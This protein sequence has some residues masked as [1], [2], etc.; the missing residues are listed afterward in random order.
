MG[1]M[2]C[3]AVEIVGWDRYRRALGPHI[4]GNDG[5]EVPVWET[6]I[7]QVPFLGPFYSYH[8]FIPEIWYCPLLYVTNYPVADKHRWEET[9]G[10][11]LVVICYVRKL[12]AMTL[13][14]IIPS[15]SSRTRKRTMMGFGS[16]GHQGERCRKWC[17][18]MG[19]KGC[20]RSGIR[21]LGLRL[22]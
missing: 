12:Y 9:A 21:G 22:I 1:G 10:N 6:I 4:R 16:R 11:Y 2:E 20:D 13:H 8:T 19:L 14:G 5:I 17:R 18:V 15:R 3:L 7:C